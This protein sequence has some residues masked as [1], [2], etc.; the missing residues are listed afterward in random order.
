M[1]TISPMPDAGAAATIV[2]VTTESFVADVGSLSHSACSAGLVGA[3]VR[4]VQTA[5]ATTRA[6]HGAGKGGVRLAK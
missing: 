2:D 4:A 5:D 6:G 1:D 3:M